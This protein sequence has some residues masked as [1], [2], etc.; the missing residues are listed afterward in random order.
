V[1][2]YESEGDVWS[3]YDLE[4]ME[5]GTIGFGGGE[6]DT[7]LGFDG[8]NFLMSSAQD[9]R[10]IDLVTGTE[11]KTVYRFP[12]DECDD[13]RPVAQ[14]G[15]TAIVSTVKYGD[16]P[17]FSGTETWMYERIRY[18]AFSVADG[19][20][21]EITGTG[22]AGGMFADG[23][24]PKMDVSTARKPLAMALCNLFF[25]NYGR[26]G[27]EPVNSKS[28]GA[29][30]DL[31]DKGCDIILAPAPT[32]EEKEYL[33]QHGVEVDR[34]VFGAD[35]LVFIGGTG[36]EISNWKELGGVDH[37]ITV[38]YRNDQSGSQRQFEK[39]VWKDETVPDFAALGFSAM[40]DMDT[41]VQ[42]CQ[43]DPYAIGYSIMTYLYDVFNN[44]DVVL[45]GIDGVAPT[46][47]TVSDNS[48]SLTLQ[49][50]VVIRSDEPE[51]SPARRLYDWFGT[52][53]SDDVL[54]LYGLTPVHSQ[55]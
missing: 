48:Y 28:H 33:S 52:P 51:D 12:D 53:Q 32:D 38:F 11:R 40:N 45:M 42:E 43:A 5:R 9:A 35:G 49:D 21:T 37:A 26:D 3:R 47:E 30:L 41:I 13:I 10:C 25:R 22:Q 34:K 14:K 8:T 15:G 1:Y 2:E 17:V 44:K 46:V 18:Y 23:S 54:R 29:W 27:A 4:T 24:F 16:A 39:L 20:V 19:S 55:P 50:C 31:A 36:T 7:V 6:L